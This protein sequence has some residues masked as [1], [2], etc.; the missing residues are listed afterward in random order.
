MLPA[1]YKGGIVFPE[2]LENTEAR[3]RCKKAESGLLGCGAWRLFEGEKGERAKRKILQ[4]FP[5]NP[6]SLF[7]RFPLLP[8]R[9]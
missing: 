8:T 3:N 7:L 2:P 9:L 5:P 6:F 1:L 4:T